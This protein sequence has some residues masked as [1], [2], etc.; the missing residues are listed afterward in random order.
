MGCGYEPAIEHGPIWSPPPKWFGGPLEHCAGYTVNL[1][2]VTEALLA[3]A[4]WKN[5]ALREW[6]GRDESTED[7]MNA[8]LIISGACSALESWAM[9]PKKDGGGGS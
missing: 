5:G 1:P 4:H 8:I 2:E 7:L 9:T 3:H 6:L